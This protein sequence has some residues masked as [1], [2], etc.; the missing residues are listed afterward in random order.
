MA[1]YDRIAS[2][3]HRATGFGGGS[4]KK[5]VLNDLILSKIDSVSGRAVLEL[6]AGN[7]YFMRLLMQ[8]FSGQA[9]ARTVITDQSARLL[10]L[11]QRQLPIDGAEYM[12]LDV[13]QPFPLGTS[14]TDLLLATMVF[15][16]VP[17]AGLCQALASCRRVLK[18]D[19]QIVATVVHPAFVASL[20]QRGL[21]KRHGGRLTMP[22]SDGLRLPVVRRTVDQYRL[23]LQR[24]GFDHT[25]EDVYPTDKLL[26]AK[27]ALRA[28]GGIPLALLCNCSR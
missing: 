9:P 28:A 8:R 23:A 2:A 17:D 7:G 19:G 16:E 27:P 24:A 12:Q 13:R 22:G 5:L 15:N 25:C 1:Y 4:F 26:N 20:D 10:A 21:L 18:P 6:G 11:A 14:S 3:W